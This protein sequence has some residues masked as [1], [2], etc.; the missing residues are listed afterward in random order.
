M[1]H[2]N[3][4]HYLG[5]DG[6]HWLW[7]RGDRHATSTPFGQLHDSITLVRIQTTQLILHLDAG[8]AAEINEILAF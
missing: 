1:Q 4:A 2:R 6:A 8:L 5:D 3:R 7:R